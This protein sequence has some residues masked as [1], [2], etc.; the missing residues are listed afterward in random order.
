[1]N[2]SA[3]KAQSPNVWSQW[4]PR[5]SN[6]PNATGG[7]RRSYRPALLNWLVADGMPMD[8]LQPT[9]APKKHLPK[10]PKSKQRPRKRDPGFACRRYKSG[11]RMNHPTVCVKA[12]RQTTASHKNTSVPLWSCYRGLLFAANQKTIRI[13]RQLLSHLSRLIHFPSFHQRSPGARL[14]RLQSNEVN[15]GIKM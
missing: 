14:T 4:V 2:S 11:I 6:A 9:R 13:F 1:M 7:P 3:R 10:V 5:I 8:I 15:C 12:T